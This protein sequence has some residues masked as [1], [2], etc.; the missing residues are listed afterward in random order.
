MASVHLKG[1]ID[2]PGQLKVTIPDWIKIKPGVYDI[3][4][5]GQRKDTSVSEPSE[6]T[7]EPS[8][9]TTDDNA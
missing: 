7:D 1:Y 8:D 6:L 5:R 2:E 4:V 9:K 3:T